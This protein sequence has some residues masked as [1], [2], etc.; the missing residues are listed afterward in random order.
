MRCELAA[1]AVVDRVADEVVVTLPRGDVVVLNAAAGVV[2]EAACGARDPIEA[3]AQ[4]LEQS[5]GAPQARSLRD[6]RIALS[7]LRESG[8]VVFP[9]RL[10]SS[11]CQRTGVFSLMSRRSFVAGMAVAGA[12]LLSPEIALGEDS[13]AAARRIYGGDLLGSWAEGS[14]S[15]D[16]RDWVDAT[17]RVVRLPLHVERVAPYGPYAQSMLEAL[18]PDMVVQ[19]S[20]R[21]MHASTQV[22]AIQ[23]AEAIAS[24]VGSESAVNEYLVTSTAPDLILDVADSVERL[25]TS[26]DQVQ[27]STGVPI[28]HMVVGTDDIPRAFMAM[29]DL[30]GRQDVA[31]TL[32]VYT[33]KILLT[34]AQGLELIPAEDRRRAY[35]G[36]GADGL[37]TRN[38]GTLLGRVL[39]LVGLDNVM[40]D[41]T[42]SQCIGVDAALVE[43]RDPDFVILSMV[44]CEEGSEK[45]ALIR[46]IW[47]DD[48][49]GRGRD[50]VLAP[51]YPFNWLRNS[52]FTMQTLG[53]LWLASEAYPG[54]YDY[55]MEK[56]AAEYFELFFRDDSG[57]GCAAALLNDARSIKDRS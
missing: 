11:I 38:A 26:I 14:L 8:V 31:E 13:A 17:G 41:L 21:G 57:E 32:A 6:A 2:L 29:G 28:V 7:R 37:D 24:S 12:S 1:G 42:D 30:V 4:A 15:A 16:S 19:V 46:S 39:G 3:A 20:A 55:D 25:V 5:C 45:R 56:A 23:T 54:V 35:F 47:D 18:C 10:G 36:Q 43:A 33:A 22:G 52:P 48:C 34:F 40:A 53:A 27:D 51:T 49:L 44:D 50:V 9:T